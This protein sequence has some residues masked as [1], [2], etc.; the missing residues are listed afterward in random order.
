MSILEIL[1][2]RKKKDLFKELN[3]LYGI[4]KAFLKKYNY[5]ERSDKVWI[6]SK[7][8]LAK[9]MRGLNIESI[10]MLFARRSATIKL[11]TNAI[12][13]IGKYATKNILELNKKDTYN[14]LRGL[15]LADLNETD[16]SGYVIVKSG[17]DFLGCALYKDGH[18]KNQVPKQRRIKKF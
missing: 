6:I 17:N 5:L 8:I 4:D 16:V 11:T 18:L 12:Q 9:D 10:G 14:Y 1:N 2:T 15:D 13:L 3:E 7:N